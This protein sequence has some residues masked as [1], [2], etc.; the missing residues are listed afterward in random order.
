MIT[1]PC[2]HALLKPKMYLWVNWSPGLND[3][4]LSTKHHFII[5]S[6]FFTTHKTH[7]YMLSYMH[8]P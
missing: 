1:L 3:W 5:I 4:S 7:T 6:F 2:S 8:L